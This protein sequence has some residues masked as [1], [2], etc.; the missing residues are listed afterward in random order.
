MLDDQSVFD[1]LNIDGI[2]DAVS[3]LL[4]GME[5]DDIISAMQKLGYSTEDIAEKIKRMGFDGGEALEKLST[6]ANASAKSTG[7]LG[8]AFS[9]LAAKIGIS[10]T[11]LGAFIAVAAGIAVVV[12]G[13]RMYNQYIQECVESAKT[14]TNAWSENN[15]TLDAQIEKIEELKTA[16][17]NGTLS[18]QDAYDAKAELYSIQQQLVETYGNQAS[19]IDLVNGELQKQ[20]DLVRELSVAE[21]ERTLN[22]N[23]AGIDEAVRQMTDE[24][25]YNLG[26][27]VNSSYA[28]LR[29][30]QKAAVQ[31]LDEILEKYDDVLD[32]DYNSN[33]PTRTIYF[34][35]NVEEADE[36]INNFMA[37]VRAKSR[38]LGGS[39]LLD[40]LLG[41][42]SNQLSD[43]NE[44]LANYQS[45][46]EQAMQANLVSDRTKY[47]FGDYDSQGLGRYS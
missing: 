4:D 21:A 27:V 41:T 22:S 38:E 6:G 30:D 35:G 25:T 3:E 47:T 32:V 40:G 11:A 43:V 45:L 37:D 34:T 26:T 24:R 16:L 20:I 9:G 18:E 14:A 29:D 36:V 39:S 17:D 5:V 19:G 10:T 12:A 7:K 8:T 42:A 33:S 31:A 13:I 23:K 2:G 1:A 44:V 28:N 15:S 46:Y